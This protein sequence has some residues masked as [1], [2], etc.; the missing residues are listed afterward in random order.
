MKFYFVIAGIVL[1]GLSCKTSGNITGNNIIRLD[2]SDQYV[3]KRLQAQQHVQFQDF[4]GKAKVRY[5]DGDQRISFATQLR[6]KKG[7]YIWI[8]ASFLAYEVARILIR[9]DSIFAINRLEKS[10][11]ADSYEKFNTSYEIPASYNQLEA[12][13]LGNTVVNLD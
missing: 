6:M 7:Q 10:Y 1:I 2:R 13:L 12:M 11:L 9:P 8:N 5:D 3:T 4:N